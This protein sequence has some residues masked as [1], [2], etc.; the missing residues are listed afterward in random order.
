MKSVGGG[1]D[2]PVPSARWQEGE[3]SMRGVSGVTKLVALHMHWL[4]YK[5]TMGG[6]ETLNDYF[7]CSDYI[8]CRVRDCVVPV[9]H[10]GTDGNKV[11][12]R[13]RRS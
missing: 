1:T 6:S 3:E 13:R 8:G 9:Q 4:L 10:G 12:R 5:V 2:V 7:S 11:Y